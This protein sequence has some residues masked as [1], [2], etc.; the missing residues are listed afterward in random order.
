MTR[1]AYLWS[2]DLNFNRT[3]VISNPQS[4]P[5][6]SV[7]RDTKLDAEEILRFRIA[8]DHPKAYLLE[9]DQRIEYRGR[10][11]FVREIVDDRDGTLDVIDVECEAWWYRLGWRKWVG[12][13]NISKE[14]VREGLHTILNTNDTGVYLVGNE[15][16]TD[17]R[18]GSQ[19][20]ETGAFSLAENDKSLL[21]L[22]RRWAEV[23]NT[24][25]DFDTQNELVRLL[26]NR[27]VNLGVVYRHGRN[28][29]RI[30]RRRRGPDLTR[31]YPYGADG[32]NISGAVSSGGAQSITDTSYY[33]DKGVDLANL[34]QYLK[35]EVWQ[36][37][38]LVDADDLY[39]DA[40]N[41]LNPRA[42]GI[43]AHEI[44]VVALSELTGYDEEPDVGDTVR[45]VDE[46]YGLDLQKTVVRT[47]LHD[48]EPWNSVVELGDPLD[49][50][51]SQASRTS[52][53]V[54]QTSDW[55]QF[56]DQINAI[57]V[58][59]DTEAEVAVL[60]LR[61]REGGVANF[62]VDLEVTGVG[63]DGTATVRIV[64]DLTSEQWGNSHTVDYVSGETT[65]VHFTFAADRLDGEY[66]W[67]VL[68]DTVA[69]GGAGAGK[70][71]DVAADSGNDLSNA[72]RTHGFYIMAYGALLDPPPPLEIEFVG[73]QHS[74]R[75]RRRLHAHHARRH[76]GR[77][78]RGN[79]RCVRVYNAVQLAGVR[80]LRDRQRR[81]EPA[82]ATPDDQRSM[83]LR[84]TGPHR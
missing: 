3:G 78:L 55:K 41:W 71:V 9:P 19:T 23:T 50:E 67:R 34:E 77:G 4:G 38:S 83:R 64:D 24:Y 21:Y 40:S 74:G 26:A 56:V 36:D 1:K 8:A 29:S 27:G 58:R 42:E 52:G 76:A 45:V 44:N 31:L 14:T 28:V 37:D 62:H 15:P 43:D 79:R 11:Y 73:R 70:G 66:D 61:F 57:S 35:D 7:V 13:V 60:N 47:V 53:R 54:R 46:A 80:L 39:S 22:I 72:E 68:V 75:R 84:H 63:G 16:Y 51:P 69:D 32:L 2:Y 33:S 20:V 25:V 65:H 30:R 12:D 59:S 6:M 18:I 5:L 17:W 82:T 48:L 49:P 81:P 10:W